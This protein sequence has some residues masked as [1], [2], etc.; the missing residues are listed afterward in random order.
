MFYYAPSTKLISRI[1]HICNASLALYIFVFANRFHN[2]LFNIHPSTQQT[3]SNAQLI[4]TESS[5]FK[6]HQRKRKIQLCMPWFSAG[7]DLVYPC[8]I[9]YALIRFDYSLVRLCIPWFSATV[10]LIY[11]CSIVYALILRYVRFDYSLVRLCMPWF[12]DTFDLIV[13][14]FGYVC[15]GSPIHSICFACFGVVT[16]NVMSV[17]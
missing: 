3:I 1:F 17:D 7:F 13:S 5:A 4:Q 10:D 12:S 6:H 14:L 8:S 16:H 9:V 15:P 11:P 2:H